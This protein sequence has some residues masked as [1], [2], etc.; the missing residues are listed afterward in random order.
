MS[1]K[2]LTRQQKEAVGLLSIG[3]F[4]EFFDLY[5]YVH[6]AVLLNELFFPKTDP[7]TTQLIT[8]FT[9]CSSYIMR[10]LGGLFFGWIGDKIGRKHTIIIT[11][12]I[13]TFSCITM[14]MLP[15]YQDIGITASIIMILCRMLQGFSSLGECIGAMIYIT[16]FLKVPYRYIGNAI[17]LVSISLGG[18]F[19]LGISSFVLAIDINNWRWVFGFGS[20]IGVVGIVA[21]TRL[22]EVPEFVD[23]RRRVKIKEEVNNIN[24]NENEVIDKKAVIA[25]FLLDLV[26][27]VGF[28]IA[29]IFS[30]DFMKKSLGMLPSEVINQNLQLNLLK[31]FIA[32]LIVYL[33]KKNHPI[34][35]AKI[36]LIFF[37]I[38]LPFIPYCFYNITDKLYFLLIQLSL[39]ILAINS[40][41]TL[42]TVIFQY[43]PVAKRFRTIA[44]TFGIANPI[45][46]LIIPFS[47]IYF[48]NHF[49]FYGLW[50]IILPT[51]IGY[52][53][54]INYF[55][56]LEIQR[57]AYYDYP[58][59][60]PSNEDT[61]I[62][63][64]DFEYEDLGDEYEPFKNE[65]E[66]SVQLLTKLNN[67][68]KE[69]DTKLNIKLIE[70]AIT[71][72]KKWHGTQMR[73]TGDHPYYWHPLSVAGM[74]SERYLKTDM[75]VASILH[76]VVEDSECTVE[77]I[78]DKFNKRIAEIV[79]RLTKKRFENGKYIKLSLEETLNRLQKL[80]DNEALFIKQMDRQHN[81]E[82]I[83]GLS[84]EKQQK[85]A[86][87]TR[88]YF[89]RLVAIIGDKLNIYGKIHLENKMFKYCYD[90][91]KKKK[92]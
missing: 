4:L 67:L 19:A 76:D 34:K 89:V 73:K 59:E 62:N 7:L 65:C 27:P 92:R 54:A 84:P 11:T 20:I 18:L 68:S 47:L 22:R 86:E 35:I 14:M 88:N 41:G 81:L 48:I 56:K 6:M 45:A 80:D 1:N 26:F 24:I 50:F 33:V 71:F 43:F 17:I 70:K 44:L 53:W 91:L 78:E 87:E 55:K 16:E 79:D 63:E 64:E 61:A 42:G 49:G 5:I 82:T 36:A 9:F 31:C 75:V 85:M 66:Y 72:A 32:F 69:E 57:G 15:T 77:L 29:F 38:M 58:N 39:L 28:Y 13:M 30:A 21:R 37:L 40:S 23:Y 52:W 25:Y 60:D 2:K 12:I 83:E 10:P 46:N 8:A 51:T 74:V 90:I 3:T